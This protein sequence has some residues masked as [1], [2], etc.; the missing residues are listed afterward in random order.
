MT[1]EAALERVRSLLARA[2][3]ASTPEEEARSCAVMAVRLITEH[4]IA[5]SLPT[6]PAASP[7]LLDIAFRRGV[8]PFEAPPDEDLEPTRPLNYA[9][10][11]SRYAG[12]CRACG[13]RYDV[14][15]T[16][17]YASARGATHYECRSWHDG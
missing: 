17:A 16:I 9:V 15:E 11:A 3:H 12:N 8:V 10:L 5:L 7:S 4:H 2:A 13:G 6:S 1:P 14:G